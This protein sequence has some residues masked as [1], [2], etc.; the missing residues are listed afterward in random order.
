MTRNIFLMSIM[1][2]LFGCSSVKIEKDYMVHEDLYRVP[3]IKNNAWFRQ[4][5]ANPFDA[6]YMRCPDEQLIIVLNSMFC[7]KFDYSKMSDAD[8][9]NR[10]YLNKYFS[11]LGGFGCSDNRDSPLTDEPLAKRH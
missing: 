9:A 6:V 1:V 2:L 4:I 10:L 7:K 5:P 11:F 3:I 8:Y